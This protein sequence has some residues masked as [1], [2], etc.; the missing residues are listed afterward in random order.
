MV[1][2]LESAT[3]KRRGVKTKKIKKNS[4]LVMIISERSKDVID[5][6]LHVCLIENNI[7][8]TMY[9]D[10]WCKILLTQKN[11]Q[12]QVVT[13]CPMHTNEFIIIAEIFTKKKSIFK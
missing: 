6:G 12:L 11:F 7:I 13:N 5:P 2:N 9:H 10:R 8:H 1:E 4:I 3:S